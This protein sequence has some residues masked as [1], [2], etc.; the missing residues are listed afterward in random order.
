M[1]ICSTDDCRTY[2]PQW[3][4]A[5]SSGGGVPFSSLPTPWPHTW[6][7]WTSR[8]RVYKTSPQWR[9]HDL[10]D[11]MAK[12]RRQPETTSDTV[13]AKSNLRLCWR[14]CHVEVST[15]DLTT[16]I[17]S[18]QQSTSQPWHICRYKRCKFQ[19]HGA[20]LV[21]SWGLAGIF[22]ELK[23]MML[24]SGATNTALY[25]LSGSMRFLKDADWWAHQIL[26]GAALFSGLDF[27]DKVLHL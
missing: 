20:G 26:C 17:R 16:P 9:H 5:I 25:W 8:R 2:L 13:A 27:L 21:Q 23:L 3:A 7:F 24:D 6:P 4:S 12:G 10:R 15:G 14:W 22:V 11:V 1:P 19:A 18:Y